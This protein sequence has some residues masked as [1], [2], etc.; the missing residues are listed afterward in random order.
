MKGLFFN[1]IT[2]EMLEL[3]QIKNVVISTGLYVIMPCFVIFLVS[4]CGGKTISRDADNGK[5][6]SVSGECVS[7]VSDAASGESAETTQQTPIEIR[8]IS[9]ENWTDDLV[10]YN[11]G[12]NPYWGDCATENSRYIFYTSDSSINM[13][14]KKHNKCYEM[15]PLSELRKDDDGS[16]SITLFCDDEFL[17]YI[18][19]KSELYS[20][21]INKCRTKKYRWDNDEYYEIRGGR[22]Y[23]G[24]VYLLLIGEVY[25]LD[26]DILKPIDDEYQDI[27]Q[28]TFCGEWLYYA[29]RRSNQLKRIN[30]QTGIKENVIRKKHGFGNLYS[31]DNTVYYHTELD[32]FKLVEKGKDICLIKHEGDSFVNHICG[33]EL[34]FFSDD[35]LEAFDSKGNL[36]ASKKPTGDFPTSD[37]SYCAKYSYVIGNRIIYKSRES[38][39]NGWVVHIYTMSIDT[40]AK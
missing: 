31:V 24:K 6:V 27:G 15:I 18:V 20:Y 39:K 9:Q 37:L 23:K 36:I 13:I 2:G 35:R 7:F 34:Y 19:N 5:D 12:D 14:Y 4:A 30:L 11:A 10:D 25:K 29:G 33:D 22:V 32:E 40:I 3:N 17:Y 21:S 1:Q 26:N 38:T 8:D 16:L 28:C